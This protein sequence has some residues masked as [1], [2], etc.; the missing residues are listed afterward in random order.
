MTA[1]EASS[2]TKVNLGG[3]LASKK[4]CGI[5]S[6]SVQIFNEINNSFEKLH[7]LKFRVL[8]ND[9][10]MIIGLPDIRKYRI[11]HRIPSFFVDHVESARSTCAPAPVLEIAEAEMHSCRH[12]DSCS[13][14]QSMCNPCREKGMEELK[15]WWYLSQKPYTLAKPQ[16]CVHST[17][18]NKEELFGDKIVDDDEIDWKEDPFIPTLENNANE[19]LA[20]EKVNIFGNDEL[21]SK[22]KSLTSEFRD[23]F[24]ETVRD[25]PADVP[26]MEIRVDPEKWHTNKN[27]GPPRP[28]SEVRRA[29]IEKQIKLYKD[30]KVVEESLASEYSQI[31]LVPKPEPNTW[32]FCLDYIR[33]NAATVGEER[34][35]IPNIPHMLQRIGSKKAKVFG[36]MDMTS[37]YHQAPLSTAAS[38]LTAF[39]SFMGIFQWRRV[40]MGLKNAAAYFQRV[41][42]TIVLIGIIFVICELY[43]DDVFVFG[44]E[45]DEFVANLREV[46]SR[47][48]DTTLL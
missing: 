19:L 11:V 46:F 42:A 32:R 13:N 40:P 15:P 28:Q 25:K 34:H 9:I 48:E 3:N 29:A 5:V 33:L 12:P 6:C 36:T 7:C 31:H 47:S 44:K 37:G 24:S 38:I 8:D 39:I 4:S 21:K 30:L 23:I 16:L 26:P 43:I 35:P 45:D 27:R 17:I 18:L 41:M 2:T 1:K 14:L 10:D 20:F 22:L